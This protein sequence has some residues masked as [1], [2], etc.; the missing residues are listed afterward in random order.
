MDTKH[1]QTLV[2]ETLTALTTGDTQEQMMAAGAQSAGGCSVVLRL[3]VD[4]I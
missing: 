2:Q 1:R 3:F 4:H